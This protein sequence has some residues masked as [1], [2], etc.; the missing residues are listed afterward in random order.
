MAA[1]V[2]GPCTENL[3]RGLHFTMINMKKSE[4][5][6]GEAY[7]LS[8]NANAHALENFWLVLLFQMQ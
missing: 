6:P 3:W 4:D 8:F 7:I 1:I 5:I 2:W